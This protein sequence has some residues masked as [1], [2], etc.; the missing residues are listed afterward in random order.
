MT[1]AAQRPRP[2]AGVGFRFEHLHAIAGALELDRRGQS[3]KARAQDQDRRALGIAVQLD[4]P[5]I[6]R[7]GGEAERRH[8]L[9]HRGRAG[10]GSDQR[11][12]IA[13]PHRSSVFLGHR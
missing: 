5:A 1:S 13:P 3:R 2:P 8:R 7:L 4:G 11:E 12:Q 6:V 9:V 10:R